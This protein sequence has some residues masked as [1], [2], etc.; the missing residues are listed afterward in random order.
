MSKDPVPEWFGKGEADPPRQ[1]GSAEARSSV[2]CGMPVVLA[3]V[4]AGA[5][6]GAF[7]MVKRPSPKVDTTVP[8]ATR[9]VMPTPERAQPAVPEPVPVPTPPAAEPTP[10]PSPT[11]VTE[12]AQPEPA[13]SADGVEGTERLRAAQIMPVMNGAKKRFRTCY[14]NALNY[15]PDAAGKVTLSL[16]IAATGRVPVASTTQTGNLPPQVSSCIAAIAR[17]LKFPPSSEQTTVNYPLVFN[18]TK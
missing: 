17:T 16:T 1:R 15:S 18:S 9:T 6:A 12:E 7:F 11:E 8:T 14:E 5:G 3:L 13:A 4:I 10:T 2:G